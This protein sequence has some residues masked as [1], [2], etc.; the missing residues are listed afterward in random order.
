MASEKKI[1]KIIENDP[2]LLGI[3]DAVVNDRGRQYKELNDSLKPGGVRKR[4][5]KYS[6]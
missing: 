2:E 4:V 6:D 1:W 5:R 3:F